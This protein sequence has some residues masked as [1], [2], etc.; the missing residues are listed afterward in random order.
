M[1]WLS[2]WKRR[3]KITIDHGSMPS[4]GVTWFPILLHL[5]SSCGKNSDD[6]T[7]I[8]SD[9]GS[10]S[11]KIAITKS[12]GITEL[13]GEIEY[14]DYTGTPS[15]SSAWIW[16][17]KSDWDVSGT[18]DTY[19]YLYYDNTKPDN[20][21]INV[22]NTTVGSYVWDSNYKGVWHLSESSGTLYDSTSN[23]ND[24]SATGS[25]TYGYTGKIGKCLDFSGSSQYLTKATAVVAAYPVTLEVWTNLDAWSWLTNIQRFSGNWA[26]WALLTDNGGHGQFFCCAGP[27]T[28]TYATTTNTFSLGQWGYIAGRGISAT[29]RHVYL[30]ATG[31]G[32]N[33]TSRNPTS[34]DLTV[35]GGLNG[36]WGMYYA[37]GRLDEIRMSNIARSEDWLA[38][39]YE[40]ERD[41]LLSWGTQEAFFNSWIFV[42]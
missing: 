23:N 19:L 7:F 20:P 41:N 26:A 29:E 11:R 13:Y 24:M 3:V 14:W 35:I 4:G 31:K 8:F 18:V 40:T 32:T 2:N 30:N 37:N 27:S 10:N 1:V 17:S 12:D 22:V 36:Q 21:N 39:S 28:D 38:A 15:T 42:M 5:S 9:I 33:T 16:V 34:M 25:P 6:V